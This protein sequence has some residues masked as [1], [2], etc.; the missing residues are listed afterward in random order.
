MFKRELLMNKIYAI[1]FILLGVASVM[2]IHDATLLVFGL[3]IGCLL[4][5]SKENFI[6]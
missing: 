3:I 4:F 6:V 2:L 1:I 5:F